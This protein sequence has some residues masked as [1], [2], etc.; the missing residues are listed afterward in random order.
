[1][2]LGRV[3][4]NG[5]LTVWEVI[6]CPIPFQAESRP[7]GCGD[8][9]ECV[10]ALGVLGVGEGLGPTLSR[11]AP[12]SGEAAGNAVQCPGPEALIGGDGR[13]FPPVLGLGRPLHAA[14]GLWGWWEQDGRGPEVPLACLLL[15]LLSTCVRTAWSMSFPF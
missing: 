6:D 9:G 11:W 14:R 12:G 4:I 10:S 2:S 13:W 7:Q 3:R 5:A 15:T 1:M 8:L